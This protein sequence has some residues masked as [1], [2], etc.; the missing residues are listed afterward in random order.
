[1]VTRL[2]I[3]PITGEGMGQEPAS[4]GLRSSIRYLKDAT[5]NKSTWESWPKGLSYLD[6]GQEFMPP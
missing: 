2:P 6:L 3:Q 1:M 5:G 4:S